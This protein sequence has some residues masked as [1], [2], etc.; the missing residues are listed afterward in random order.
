MRGNGAGKRSS[1]GRNSSV[2][3][4]NGGKSSGNSQG[5][6][7]GKGTAAAPPPGFEGPNRRRG[8]NNGGS[9]QGP[10]PGWTGSIGTWNNS[11]S[12]A[13]VPSG[14][15][16]SST[17][18]S[19]FSYRNA[20]DAKDHGGSGGYS[21]NGHINSNHTSN[22]HNHGGARS[23]SSAANS[24]KYPHATFKGGNKANA[25][26]KIDTSQSFTQSKASTEVAG[27]DPR[28]A[29][30]VRNKFLADEMRIVVQN[31]TR[32][33]YYDQ[34][35]KRL[36]GTY[37]YIEK[38]DTECSRLHYM[39]DFVPIDIMEHKVNLALRKKHPRTTSSSQGKS[40]VK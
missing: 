12:T 38:D 30:E 40:S 8:S 26:L 14:G 3:S 24:P 25:P 5:Q 23:Y 10:G 34:A 15:K 17:G 28:W 1:G 32:K 20:A 33:S 16:S 39:K 4:H 35:S 13:P 18:K 22:Q 19:K 27:L 7:S 6:N 11:M 37:P 21:V 36:V 9:A 29:N 31:M 2:G